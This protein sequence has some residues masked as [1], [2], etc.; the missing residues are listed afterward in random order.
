MRRDELNKL[1]YL[2]H[3]RL[4]L[5]QLGD[6]LADAHHADD[7]AATIDTRRRVEQQL[8]TLAVLGE[9]RESEIVGA[10]ALERSREHFLHRNA[11]LN[12]DVRV[13]KMFTKYL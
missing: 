1:S 6:V 4:R 9:E 5:A 10:V 8:N 7:G 11:V 2:R 3:L 12:S 13:R